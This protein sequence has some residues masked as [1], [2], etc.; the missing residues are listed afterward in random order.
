MIDRERAKCRLTLRRKVFTS[1]PTA[2]ASVHPVPW[3][4]RRELVDIASIH[5]YLTGGR[6]RMLALR[7]ST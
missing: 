2:V 5:V 6:W 3:L 7:K 1:F 4:G